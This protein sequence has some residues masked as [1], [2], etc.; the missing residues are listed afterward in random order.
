MLRTKKPAM[1]VA[2]LYNTTDRDYFVRKVLYKTNKRFL[3]L[4]E[5]TIMYYAVS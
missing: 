3:I 2:A 4:Q 1:D 5:L